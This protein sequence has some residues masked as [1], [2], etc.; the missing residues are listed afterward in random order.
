MKR[1]VTTLVG[2]LVLGTFFFILPKWCWHLFLLAAGIIGIRE[3]HRVANN[4]GAKLFPIPVFLT[5]VGGIGSIYMP[6]FQL[7]FIVFLVVALCF[8]TPLFPPGDMKQ[9][10]PNAG[11]SLA[12]CAYMGFALI[13]L[14]YLF[15]LSGPLASGYDTGRIMLAFCILMVWSGDS[16]A[17]LVGSLFGT[18]KIS[19]IVSPNK[20]WEG[21][22][23]NLAGNLAFS[24]VA[25]YTFFLELSWTD[26]AVLTVIFG[27]LG[28]YGD[29][30]ESSWKRGSGI[31]DS[32]SLLPGHG[33]ILDRIDSI[34]LT[35]PIFYLY[36]TQVVL[37]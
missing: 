23:A 9:A 30:V 6:W 33:G 27:V 10:L 16:A 25:K 1:S 20:T 14:A 22:L 26:V 18:H 8:L 28:F 21:T 11:I 34:F 4:F 13:A 36:L 15:D 3:A 17:Y 35:A 24:T 2:I 37:E 5:V 32:S 29:L 19:P 7:E 12:F 31:K